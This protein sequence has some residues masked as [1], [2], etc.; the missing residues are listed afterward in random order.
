MCENKYVLAMYDVRGKQEFIFRTNKIKEM[1]GGSLLIRDVFRDYLYPAAECVKGNADIDRDC[2]K[3][4]K[5]NNTPNHKASNGIFHDNSV[6]F[7]VDSFKTHIDQENYIGEVI[8]DGGGNFYVLYKNREV[9]RSV[10]K[11]FTKELMEEVG[12]MRVLCSYKEDV[13]FENYKTDEDELRKIHRKK[14]NEESISRPVNALPVVQ[15]DVNTSMP[16]VRRSIPG[17]NIPDKTTQESY[18]KLKK[19]ND[20]ALNNPE[21]GEDVLDRIVKEKGEDSLL[22]VV[23]IDGNNMGSKVGQCLAESSDDYNSCIK[24]LRKFSA[25]IQSNYVDVPKKC[26]DE[27]LNEKSNAIVRMVVFAGDEMSFVCR[28]EDALDAVKAY[29][30]GLHKNEEKNEIRSSCAGITIFHSHAP[31]AE[32]YKIAEECCENGKKRMKDNKETDTCYIDYQYCQGGLGM[33][34]H[35]IRDIETK[36]LVSK[37]WLYSG[38]FGIK[39]KAEEKF[40]FSEVLAVVNALNKMKARTNIKGL[41]NAAK[42]SLEKFDM[43]MERIYA[44]MKKDLQNDPMIQYLF[45]SEDLKEEKLTGIKGNRRRKLVYDIGT[46]YDI[47][48]KRGEE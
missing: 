14:E 30:D 31:Y 23:Y 46:A 35:T 15:I 28:A 1:V 13:N 7:S 17:K 10:N 44:H 43:E 29:F 26:I 21:Y 27:L 19:Y 45:K 8:Y 36:N 9:L 6:D 4:R 20:V 25:E 5:G 41:V 16:I 18:A 38:E 24:A 22:A 3:E 2:I 32:A 12:T 37:P 47:W 40:P 48:F 39:A 33:D 34:L 42:E 11:I